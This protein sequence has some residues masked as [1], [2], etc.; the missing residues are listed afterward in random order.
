MSLSLHSRHSSAESKSALLGDAP[1]SP[2]D[3]LPVPRSTRSRRV[4]LAACASLGLSSVVAL[5]TFALWS[6]SSSSRNGQQPPFIVHPTH[7]F[8]YDPAQYLMGPPTDSFRENLRPELQYI[9]S[10]V[11][12][13]WTN[14]V[15]TYTNLIY[16]AIITRRIPIIGAFTPSHVGS[17]VPPIPFG[18]VFDVP[19]LSAEIGVPVLEWHQVKNPESEVIDPVGCWNIWQTM[20]PSETVAH[21]SRVPHLVGLD[22]SYTQVPPTVKLPNTGPNDLHVSY[23]ALAALGFP[24]TYQETVDLAEHAPSPQ[25]GLE[26]LPDEQLMCFDFLYYASVL[27]TY[28]YEHDYS[29]AWNAVAAHM[30]WEPK[31]QALADSY[32]RKTFGVSEHDDVPPFIS[33]HIRR[34]DFAVWCQLPVEEC[35]PPLSAYV[36]AVQAVKDELLETR[37][38]SVEHV[39]VTSDERDPDW[40]Q[41]IAAVGWSFPDHSQTSALYGKWYPVL[42]D[43]VIQSGG[44]GFVGTWKSTMSTMAR[45]RSETWHNGVSRTVAFPA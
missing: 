45:R 35:F 11:S 6:S 34:A 5:A 18:E 1:R 9:T 22:I 10:W 16:L 7:E 29:P 41:E 28:E 19:R 25:L 42:I 43:A 26:L 15:M 4:L 20:R 37:G 38:L 3:F 27:N 39:I 40:W 23:W 24:R 30:H 8:E 17:D 2:D 44:V 31:L 12:A 21:Y 36:E 14:D 33:L 13:G 32:L